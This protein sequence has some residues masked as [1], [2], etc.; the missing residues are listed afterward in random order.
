MS[1]APALHGRPS[2]PLPPPA[3]PRVLVRYRIG[4]DLRFIS[5]HDEIRMLTRTIVRARWPLA[6]SSGFNPAPRLAILLPRP[7]GAAARDQLALVRLTAPATPAELAASLRAALPALCGL[8]D[9][10]TYASSAAPQAVSAVWEL[11]LA[12]DDAAGLD[13]RI[14]AL[15]AG[16]HWP[17]ERVDRDGRR[18][19]RVDIRPAIAAIELDHLTLRITLRLSA[20]VSARPTELTAA[21]GLLDEAYG[22]RWVRCAV[23]WNIPSAAAPARGGPQPSEERLELAEQDHQED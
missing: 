19:G 9:V 1:A 10:A 20:G 15:L 4:G 12:A 7:V 21:L 17:V 14:A 22:H 13:P 8:D 5:H 18:R 2:G 11:P 6:Y 23:H 3:A 16:E